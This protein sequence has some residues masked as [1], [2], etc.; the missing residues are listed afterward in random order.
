LALWLIFRRFFGLFSLLGGQRGNS[1]R[2]AVAVRKTV[3]YLMRREETLNTRVFSS[4]K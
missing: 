3:Q 2:N 1:M 4:P